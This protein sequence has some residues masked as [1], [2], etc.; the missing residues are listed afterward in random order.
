MTRADA[1]PRTL[2]DLVAEHT[3]TLAAAG[4]ASP[5]HDAIALARHVLGLTTTGIRTASLPDTEARR[6]LADLVAR[7]ADREP[8]QLIV[9]A[10]WFRYLRLA[11]RD[12]V[13]I[14]RPETEVV[15]GLAIDAAR[16]AGDRPSVV[17]P[18]TG[19]GAIALAVATEV[20]GAQVVATELDPL[21]LDLARTNLADVAR[22][23]AEVAGL[24]AGASCEVLAG[25]LLAPVDPGLRGHVDVLV[26]NPPY[27][28]AADASTMDPEVTEHDPDRALFGGPDG[29]EVVDAL[30]AAAADWLAPGGTVVLEIDA[31]RAS[32]AVAAAIGVG[33]ID[34]RTAPD[35]TGADRALVARRGE[36][37]R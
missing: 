7:R 11:C 34:V 30:L 36:E 26:S 13:F 18:C 22:G 2:H 9:G 15:A 5:H 29:H 19:T 3:A 28:P 32:D 14:P 27:L 33:L 25:D 23:R 37:R 10:T 1:S 12:G 20:P 17:E 31:R 21:A 35:L 6:A 4:V 24:A 8:L 16:R